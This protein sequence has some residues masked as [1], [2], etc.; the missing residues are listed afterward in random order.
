[1]PRWPAYLMA[2]ACAA[3]AYPALTTEPPGASVTSPVPPDTRYR[4][5][6]TEPFWSVA[7][8]DGQMVY[9]DAERRRVVAPAPRHRTSFNGHRYESPRLTLDVT[10]AN[11]S[12]GMSDN[13][14]PD[15]VLVVVDGRELRGCGYEP[16]PAAGLADTAW[17]IVSINGSDVP[18]GA[19]YALNFTD[20]GLTGRAGCNRFNGSY[21]TEGERLTVSPLAVTRMACPGVFMAHERFVL[22]LFGAP[23]RV[24]FR[25]DGAVVLSGERGWIRLE[26]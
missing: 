25:R 7:I 6:G 11:C 15:T 19:D 4:A 8:A 10:H 3:C 22:D 17:R 16:R 14:Y 23:V 13:L 20:N 12:D 5:L 21:R 18:N 2:A 26:R 9:E 1:M 24:D